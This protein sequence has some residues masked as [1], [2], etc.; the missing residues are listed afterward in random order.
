MFN[1]VRN[2]ILNI[3][4]VKFRATDISWELEEDLGS[5]MF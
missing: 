1:V 2:M 4:Q 5:R 3:S